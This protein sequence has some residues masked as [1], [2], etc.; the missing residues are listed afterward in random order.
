MKDRD[1]SRNKRDT[2]EEGAQQQRQWQ[3]QQLA[4]IG[5]AIVIEGEGERRDWREKR[6]RDIGKQKYG[7]PPYG[8]I[9]I[10]LTR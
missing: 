7:R 8:R 2:G 4:G 6:R 5:W 10:P 1:E 3:H 9:E